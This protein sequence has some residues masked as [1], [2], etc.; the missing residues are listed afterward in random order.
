MIGILPLMGK[1]SKYVLQLC[2]I[3]LLTHELK[4]II[5]MVSW[6]LFSICKL[7]IGSAIVSIYVSCV[8]TV[9]TRKSE[10]NRS[11]LV[12]LSMILFLRATLE[13]TFSFLV[14]GTT[15]NLL[16]DAV[17]YLWDYMFSIG[18]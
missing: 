15:I 2:C 3:L 11:D 10:Y 7:T 9:N 8:L 13:I 1:L 16:W 18:I 14:M 12:D 4:I 5:S 6:K 17:D